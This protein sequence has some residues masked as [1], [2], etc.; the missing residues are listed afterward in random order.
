MAVGN[1]FHYSRCLSESA[2]IKINLSEFQERV[3]T[4]IHTHLLEMLSKLK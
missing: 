3:H 2:V 1:K 4:S